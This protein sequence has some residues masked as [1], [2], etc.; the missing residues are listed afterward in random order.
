MFKSHN[1]S[2]DLYLTPW[3]WNLAGFG[4]TADIKCPRWANPNSPDI[5]GMLPSR[6]PSSTEFSYCLFPAAVA[7][8]NSVD[9]GTLTRANTL[10]QTTQNSRRRVIERTPYAGTKFSINKASLAIVSFGLSGNIGLVAGIKLN[11]KPSFFILIRQNH[12]FTERQF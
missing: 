8:A 4:L 12:I 3:N 9:F 7:Q 1:Y 2:A 11:P 6:I 10:R 5:R